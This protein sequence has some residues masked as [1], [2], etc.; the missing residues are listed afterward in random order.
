MVKRVEILLR[1][2]VINLEIDKNKENKLKIKKTFF[3]GNQKR[4]THHRYAFSPRGFERK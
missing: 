3:L 1:C 4:R 2:A